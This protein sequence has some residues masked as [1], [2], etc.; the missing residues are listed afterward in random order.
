MKGLDFF[1]SREDMASLLQYIES[2]DAV[3][4][5]YNGESFCVNKP[6]SDTERLILCVFCHGVEPVLQRGD[7]ECH[8]VG[9]ESDCIWLSVNSDFL[10]PVGISCC[11]QLPN[12]KTIYNK[13]VKHIQKEFIRTFDKACYLGP[14][15][16]RA[17]K[18]ESVSFRFYV[19]AEASETSYVQF[20]FT[21]FVREI[22]EKGLFIIES[23]GRGHRKIDEALDE[24]AE[25][26][27]IFY[28]GAKLRLDFS[29]I[30]RES[31]LNYLPSGK[32]GELQVTYASDEVRSLALRNGEMHTI[33]SL[34]ENVS[35]WMPK[36][37]TLRDFS[38]FPDSEAITLVHKKT[39][40]KNVWQFIVDARYLEKH[41]MR[42][43]WAVVQDS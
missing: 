29:S 31:D 33:S 34:A 36:G 8:W 24:K 26:Y 28:S 39:A 35:G 43:M 15:L 42:E 17:W 40:R 5:R 38:Y 1:V 30:I 14:D 23:D 32:Q 7:E 6:I 25:Q 19:D 12:V 9:Q 20:D 41:E 10:I 21:E 3:I 11:S 16:Y 2:M 18:N 27:L 22:K 4:Y 37:H 13:I